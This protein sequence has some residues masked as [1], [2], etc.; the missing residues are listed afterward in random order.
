MTLHSAKA[1][2]PSLRS[3]SDTKRRNTLTAFLVATA[4]FMENLDATVITTAIPAMARDF[5][6]LPIELNLGISAYLLTLG[7]FIPISGWIADRYGG[8]RVFCSALILFTLASLACGLVNNLWAFI[9]LRVL[10]GI[11]GAMMVPV[12]RLV[13]LRNTPKQDLLKMMSIIIWPGLLA[14][15]LG[16][17][18]G[19]LITTYA[20][21]R[22]IFY[23]NIPIGLAAWAAALALIPA[24][25][26]SKGR[27]FDWRGFLWIGGGLLS[28]LWSL[29]LFGRSNLPWKQ[30]GL[31]FAIGTT[32]LV[33]GIRHLGRHEHPMLSL[34][35]LKRRTYAVNIFGGSLFRMSVGAVPFLLPL[36][37]QIGYGMDAL[38]SGLFVLAVFAGNISMKP[39][40][41][42]VMKR[43]GFRRVLVWNGIFNT[44]ALMTC[45]LIGPDMPAGAI[46]LV[47]FV[48]GLSRSMQFTALNTLAFAEMPKTEMS[49][50]NSLFS[51][52]SQ[53]A[54]G[55]G[56][57]LGAIGIRI[58]EWMTPLLGVAHLPGAEYRLAFLFVGLVSLIGMLD[59]FRLDS[60]AGQAVSNM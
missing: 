33:L 25:R 12:G 20:S 46:A 8:R 53:L 49:A 23:L 58:G 31:S 39:F 15:V 55:M 38:H 14:P 59:L 11:G 41:S 7:V 26:T 4:F 56:I 29:E 40:T 3:A 10:Q 43:F 54:L 42:L 17:P 13:L 30:I 44:I 21:W 57:A 35:P 52:T 28:L 27:P 60:S 37:F 50:A 9:A 34:T 1:A 16:P 2:S 51:T 32:F 5:G 6:V 22:W 19:G 24:E 48:G 47:L 45:A 36:M 18:L